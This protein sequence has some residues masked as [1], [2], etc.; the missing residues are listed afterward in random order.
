VLSP[1]VRIRAGPREKVPI[2]YATTIA[3]VPRRHF[4]AEPTGFVFDAMFAGNTPAKAFVDEPA[5]PGVSLLWDTGRCFYVGDD[6]ANDKQYSDAAAFVNERVGRSVLET[7]HRGAKL[8]Y[9]SDPCR[10][11][12]AHALAASE[13]APRGRALYRHDLRR[14]PAAPA[15]PAGLVVR[16]IDRDLLHGPSLEHISLSPRR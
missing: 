8:Y 1:F 13:P 15:V 16:A 5:M 14:L 9:A 12:L 2:V 4:A 11:A 7:G 6:S 10:H 3:G